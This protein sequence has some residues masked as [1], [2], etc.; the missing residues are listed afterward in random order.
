MLYLA[1]ARKRLRALLGQIASLSEAEFPYQY[2][3]EAL[4][5]IRALFNERLHILDSYH[6][7]NIQD[8]KWRE[9]VKQECA[10]S[11]NLCFV[12]L[13][14]LGFLLR[15]TNVR[16][17]FEAFGPLLRLS[18]EMLEPDIEK[19]QERTTKLIL[20]SEW[21]Y[22][23]L[24]YLA[25]PY[26][27][28]F[29]LIGLPAPESDNP[30]LLPLAGHELG[31]SVWEKC[32][33]ESTYAVLLRHEVI[34]SVK[35]NRVDFQQTFP[36]LTP[37]ADADLTSNMFAIRAW[38]PAVQWALRQAQE[39]FCDFIGLRLF[40]SA[41]LSAFAYLIAPNHSG[42]RCNFY[43]SLGDRVDN[44][45]RAA[46]QYGIA[47]PLDYEDMFAD[48]ADSHMVPADAFC[49]SRADDA[50]KKL[51][52]KLISQAKTIVAE[53]KAPLPSGEEATRIIEQ[54][55][56]VSPAE[57]TRGLADI[58]NAAW[59]LSEDH[60]LWCDK[61][62]LRDKQERILAELVLKNIELHEIEQ[63]TKRTP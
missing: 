40:G 59:K 23:P 19:E 26:L 42:Q 58:L 21:E 36:Y 50:V 2:S 41:Y 15:S 9:M 14:L 48:E 55:R 62:Q 53:T 61:P 25:V 56:K 12:Y 47:E 30:L 39:T 1:Y 49:L 6:S 31:H 33:L 20:S 16:N 27:P 13:P 57:N 51:T 17:A 38:E 63:R 4:E 60:T 52:D 3:R 24:T 32:D 28:D 45:C 46:K 18:R 11:L 54:L 10:I 34:K 44:L 29:V 7:D 22:S 35:N 43:P 5:N 8:E 37:I